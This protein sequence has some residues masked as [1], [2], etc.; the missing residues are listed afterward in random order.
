VR[1]G[2][3]HDVLGHLGA[4]RSVAE[5]VGW[6][7]PHLWWLAT[8]FDH[9]AACCSAPSS[10]GI[11]ALDLRI[12]PL[13]DHYLTIIRPPHSTT[14]QPAALLLRVLASA[15]LISAFDH[16]LTII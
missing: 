16:Y 14:R 13:F 1:D 15:H 2:V 10:A 9:T 6:W 11:C 4:L 5:Q 12:L 8:T 7:P 3:T